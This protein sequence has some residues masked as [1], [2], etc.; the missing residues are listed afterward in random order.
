MVQTKEERA[1]YIRDYRIKNKQKLIEKRR[2]Y[3]LKNKVVIN[4]NQKKYRENNIDAIKEYQAEYRINNAEYF[5]NYHKTPKGRRS[6]TLTNWRT[7]GLTPPIGHTL[8]T[9]YDDVYLPCTA[10]QVCKTEFTST[11]DRCADHD[12]SIIENNFRQILCQ[13][14]N[15]YDC[16]K[17]YIDAGN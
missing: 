1:Q 14:C 17:K 7:R 2:E 5:N 11:S 13:R 3:H 10:C 16:W 8:H 9:L 12:H 6:H 15:K 4:A